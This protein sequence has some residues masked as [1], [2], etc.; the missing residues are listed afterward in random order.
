[1][2]P[3]SPLKLPMFTCLVF[4]SFQSEF[5]YY[6]LGDQTNILPCLVIAL[7]CMFEITEDIQFI[8]SSYLGDGIIMSCVLFIQ[9]VQT[10]VGPHC[11]PLTIGRCCLLQSRVHRVTSR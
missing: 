9:R 2:A 1:M 10:S 4:S 3:R 5:A 7:Y 8:I 11:A 6:F